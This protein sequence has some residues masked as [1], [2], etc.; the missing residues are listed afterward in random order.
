MAVKLHVQVGYAYAVL[1]CNLIH[2]HS[3]KQWIEAAAGMHEHFF[4]IK[5][6]LHINCFAN[7]IL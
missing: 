6:S 3:L 1:M 7:N 5:K 4:L 2:C